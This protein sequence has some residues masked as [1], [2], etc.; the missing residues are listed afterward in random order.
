VW[1]DAEPA[2]Q[3]VIETNYRRRGDGVI[4]QTVRQIDNPQP[5]D[6]DLAWARRVMRER[7][8]VE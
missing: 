7:L 5:R 3:L 2:E 1:L 6:E 8:G 4:A